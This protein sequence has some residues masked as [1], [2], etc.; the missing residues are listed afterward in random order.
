MA[1]AVVTPVM[2]LFL[3]QAEDCIRD[4]VR[5]R[6]RGDVYKRQ[7]EDFAP[8]P[9]P[10]GEVDFGA[11]VVVGGEVSPK[12]VGLHAFGDHGLS[13]GMRAIDVG[14]L[15]GD[16]DVMPDRPPVGALLPASGALWPLFNHST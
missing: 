7:E 10:E 6:G 8:G 11:A 5:S 3:C 13:F 14:W 9:A 4:L 16:R 15:W 12:Q 1:R 2:G